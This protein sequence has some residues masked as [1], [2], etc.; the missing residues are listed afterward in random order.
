MSILLAY[1]HVIEPGYFFSFFSYVNKNSV[2]VLTL[3]D[4][5]LRMRYRNYLLVQKFVGTEWYKKN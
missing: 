4:T 2:G 1:K 5:E 3:E